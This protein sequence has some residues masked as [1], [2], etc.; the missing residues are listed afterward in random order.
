M[1]P[2]TLYKEILINSLPALTTSFRLCPAPYKKQ[3]ILIILRD[4]TTSLRNPISHL[5]LPESMPQGSGKGKL[6]LYKRLLF[7]KKRVR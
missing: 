6:H 4:K 1:K 3:A 2:M 5:K 7:T